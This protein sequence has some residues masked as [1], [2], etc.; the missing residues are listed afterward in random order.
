MAIVA[1]LLHHPR[2]KGTRF[3]IQLLLAASFAMLPQ[4]QDPHCHAGPGV[5]PALKSLHN[6]SDLRVLDRRESLTGFVTVAEHRMSEDN[7]IRFMRCDHSLLG[8][9][10][11]DDTHRAMLHRVALQPF[12]GIDHSYTIE[13]E[14]IYTTFLLQEAI[15]LV[16]QPRPIGSLPSALIMYVGCHLCASKGGLSLRVVYSSGLG[17]GTSARGLTLHGA[18]VTVVEIDPAVYHF[19]RQYFGMPLPRGGVHLEDARAYL[20]RATTQQF[21]WVIHDV[22]TGGSVPPR[23]F[24]SEC[25]Q[26]VK[27]LLRP[28]GTLAVVR[29]VHHLFY[30]PA[31]CSVTI[32]LL[33]G[34]ELCW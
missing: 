34:T 4:M 18:K 1:S 3:I 8:G 14:S 10:W 30:L 27:S 11:V 33:C 6:S 19:A 7:W 28:G 21:D 22:F 12:G 32:C 23:L 9:L 2:S 20:G 31:F 17:I 15:R 25:W 13:P 16:D 29:I 5:S 24:T 26:H